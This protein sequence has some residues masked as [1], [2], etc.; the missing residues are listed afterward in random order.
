MVCVRTVHPPTSQSRSH[1]SFVVVARSKAAPSRQPPN[2]SHTHS[3]RHLTVRE[4]TCRRQTRVDLTVA[5]G[6]MDPGLLDGG[7]GQTDR[8]RRFGVLES[9]PRT[10]T[11]QTEACSGPGPAVLLRL[12]VSARKKKR[13]GTAAGLVC[14]APHPQGSPLW[15]EQRHMDGAR[16]VSMRLLLF[17]RRRDRLVA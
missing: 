17:T 13:S 6:W 7:P 11:L 5:C 12:R 15:T 10:R 1:V 3:S 4:R 2:E 16:Q 8:P 14:S 9:G